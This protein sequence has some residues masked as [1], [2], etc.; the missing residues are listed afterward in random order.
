MR[1][2][3]AVMLAVGLTMLTLALGIAG[4]VLWFRSNSQSV[5]GTVV[6]EVL[7]P[8]SDGNAYCPVV[9]YTTRNGQTLEHYSNICA[10]PA[11]YQ[12]GD[13]V[14]MYYNPLNPTSVQMS[15]FFGTWFMPLLFGFM[16]VIFTA[17]GIGMLAPDFVFNLLN[18]IRS[19]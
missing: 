16:G 17:S 3:G 2:G 9:Q 15:N 13:E 19:Q 7:T 8:Y 14:R 5:M 12:V 10:W 11:T 18:R 6:A 4:W 1:I